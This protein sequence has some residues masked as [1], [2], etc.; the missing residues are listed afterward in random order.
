MA[1][2]NLTFDRHMLARA[3]ATTRMG[4]HPQ[5]HTHMPN[6]HMHTRTHKDVFKGSRV[7]ASIALLSVMRGE[8]MEIS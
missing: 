5:E 8:G 4:T 7:R 1:D 3:Q 6:T 2:V